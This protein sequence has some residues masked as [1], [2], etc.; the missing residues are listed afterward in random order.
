MVFLYEPT[1][2]SGWLR[3]TEHKQSE[4]LKDKPECR[5]LSD[6]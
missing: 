5:K 2:L 1:L 6:S 3:D 4:Y